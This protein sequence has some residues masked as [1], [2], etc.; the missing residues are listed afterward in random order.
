MRPSA[1]R[2]G[3]ERVLESLDAEVGVLSADDTPTVV[4]GCPTTHRLDQR[5]WRPALACRSSVRRRR[6]GQVPHRAVAAVGR[7][8]GCAAGRRPGWAEDFSR[9]RCCCCAA[10]PGYST[11]RSGQL[12]TRVGPSTNASG[13]S[14]IC[15]GSSVASPPGSR[16]PRFRHGHRERAEPGRSELAMLHLARPGRAGRGVGQRHRDRAA[17]AAM[18]TAGRA[19]VSAERGVPAR[20]P[21]SGRPPDEA[22]GRRAPARAAAMGARCAENGAVVGSLVGDLPGQPAHASPRPRSRPCSPSPTRSAWPCPTPRRWPRPSTPC[23][24]R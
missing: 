11:W 16:W 21:A 15:P 7:R 23:A 10:W 14:S 17:P 12:Q 5:Q 6:A 13:C 18:G 24:T 3:V 1:L 4:V 22:R 9:P 19:R 8:P 20:R 2:A